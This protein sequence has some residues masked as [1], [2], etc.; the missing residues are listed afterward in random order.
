ML[1]DINI[2]RHKLNLISLFDKIKR[3]KLDR[4][5]NRL[6]ALEI[7]EELI[8]K[9]TRSEQAIRKFK[10]EIKQSQFLLSDRNNSKETSK[11]IKIKIEKLEYN[12]R[13]HRR[14]IWVYKSVGDCIPFIYGNCW[15]LKQLF[16]KQDAGFISGKKGQSP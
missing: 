8:V 12:L 13:L 11:Q 7:Q 14:L 4:L 1:A 6:L 2:S 15:D 9:I 5:S 16:L 10:A 3:L